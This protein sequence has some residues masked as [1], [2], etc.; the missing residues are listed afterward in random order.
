MS[1]SFFISANKNSANKILI[2][3]L[4][5]NIWNIYRWH[6]IAEI[7]LMLRMPIHYMTEITK[8]ELQV[9]IPFASKKNQPSCLHSTLSED[10]IIQLI[11]NE[12]VLEKINVS[13]GDNKTFPFFKLSGE[14]CFLLFKPEYGTVIDRNK[15]VLT[16]DFTGVNESKLIEISSS[17]EILLYSRMRYTIDSGASSSIQRDR[18]FFSESAYIDLRINEARTGTDLYDRLLPVKIIQFFLIAPLKKTTIDFGS[19]KHSVRLLEAE[20]WKQYFWILYLVRRPLLV[21]YWKEN[22]GIKATNKISYNTLA[23]VKSERTEIRYFLSLITLLVMITVIVPNW[24]YIIAF[25]NQTLDS[26]TSLWKWILATML[27]VISVIKGAVIWDFIKWCY[28]SILT[29]WSKRKTKK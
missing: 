2:E 24:S 20:S 27:L 15:L 13:F 21:H 5:I 28:R 16:Y 17:D 26:A 12:Q 23:M 29:L 3:K 8:I 1:D 14:Q 19:Q 10:K 4:H 18:H 6:M 9:N 25:L 22:L 11:F 7:G